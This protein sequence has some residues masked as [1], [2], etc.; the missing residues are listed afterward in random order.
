MHGIS[1]TWTAIPTP[2]DVGNHTRKIIRPQRH[3]LPCLSRSCS[4]SALSGP[5]GSQVFN[6]PVTKSCFLA[7]VC[8]DADDEKRRFA[9]G[10]RGE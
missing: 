7:A 1:V 3:F 10:I 4:Q 5:A 6:S 9:S 8:C 2:I